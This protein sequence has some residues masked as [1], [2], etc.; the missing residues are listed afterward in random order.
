LTGDVENYL[1]RLEEAEEST[2]QADPEFQD[3]DIFEKDSK[4]TVS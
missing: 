4:M 1:K 2:F 3:V